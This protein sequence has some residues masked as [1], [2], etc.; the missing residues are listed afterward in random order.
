MVARLVEQHHVGSHQQDARER[1]AH[2]PAARELA[3]V[4]VHHLLAEAQA[5]EHL[6]CPALQRVAVELLE[7]VLHL[8]IAFENFLHLVGLVGVGHLG[9]DRLQFG[10]DFGHGTS[11]VHR[12][13]NRAAARHL[14]D[15]LAEVTDGHAAI[16]RDLAFVGLILAGDQTEQRRLAGA[17]GADEADLLAALERGGGLDEDDLVAILLADI[18]EANH[19]TRNPDDE[20]FGRL[21]PMR[22]AER[23]SVRA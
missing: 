16:D 18:V 13:G 10:G 12:F 21:M 7:A 17:V 8:A 2:L 1:D 5:R 4:A 3:D 19:G 11:A 15:I 9:F 20:L 23:K 22:G 6:A 14:A